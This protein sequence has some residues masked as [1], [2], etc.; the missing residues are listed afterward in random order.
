MEDELNQQSAKS[1]F[2]TMGKSNSS[3]AQVQ[4][5]ERDAIIRL[6]EKTNEEN[7]TRIEKLK[8]TIKDQKETIQSLQNQLNDKEEKMSSVNLLLEKIKTLESDKQFLKQRISVL[9]SAKSSSNTP[10]SLTPRTQTTSIA[11]DS[12]GVE[13][14]K[15][16]STFTK[17][18]TSVSKSLLKMQDPSPSNFSSMQAPLLKLTSTKVQSLVRPPVNSSYLPSYH[19]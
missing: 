3:N 19:P 9:I 11:D 7:L 16:N 6:Y 5:L 17:L 10:K 1:F 13:H 18:S 4:I 2:R 8:A 14:A 15:H 12:S